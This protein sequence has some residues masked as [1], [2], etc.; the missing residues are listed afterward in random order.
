[1][2]GNILEQIRAQVNNL[3][4]DQVREQL[5]KMQTQRAKQRERQKGKE[6]TE[7]QLEKRKEYNRTRIQ[8]PEVK[9]KMKE[10]HQRPEVKE[11]MKAY[12]QKRAAMLKAVLARAAE[13]GINPK[14]GEVEQ[15]PA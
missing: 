10:Y 14:T 11:R 3:S 7:E 12:R 8:K 2:E 9:A 5:A 1:M 13:L 15:Q 4:A 6:L